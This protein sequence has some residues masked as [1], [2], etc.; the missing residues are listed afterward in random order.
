M[1]PKEPYHLFDDPLRYYNEMIEDI[2]KAS[3]YVYIETFRVGKDEIGERFRRVLTKKAKEGV[4][5]KILIDYWGAGSIDHDYFEK[6]IEY[7]GEVRFFEKI[8][9]NSDI[10]TR[11]HRRNHRKFLLIDDVITYIGSSNLTGYN[12]NW[13]ESVLRMRSDITTAF[14]KIFNQDFNNYNKYSFHK[15]YKTLLIKH[16]NF[17]IVRDV[18]S[19][20]RKNINNK[21]IRLI[22]NSKSRVTIE[23]PYFLPGFFL[24]KALMDT[25]QRGISVNVIMPR[26]SDVTLIDILRKKYFGMLY[27]AGV[28]LMFYELNNLHAKMMLVDK[29][30]FA[31]G[32]SN[33]DY[34]SFR[35]MY[36]IMMIGT[37]KDIASQVNSHM[38]ITLSDSTKFNYDNWKNRSPINKLFEWILLPFRHL[39]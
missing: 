24:R 4:E 26:N 28:N 8:K 5:I 31:I 13:R 38:K 23:T 36:E 35:Y 17:E 15:P 12:I 39:L 25:A 20:A 6:L 18:P 9:F 32:S 7:K 34:R 16:G 14:V 30:V 1:E 10:F 19:I 29:K 21:F 22:K 11:S 2:E 37:N 33:F 3:K 27:K